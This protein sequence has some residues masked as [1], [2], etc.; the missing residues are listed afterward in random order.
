VF[1]GPKIRARSKFAAEIM[2]KQPILGRIFA[3]RDGTVWQKRREG[4]ERHDRSQKPG[5][6]F[7]FRGSI[8]LPV[9][10]IKPS[11]GV[12]VGDMDVLPQKWSLSKGT[13]NHEIMITTLE[14]EF[15]D[16]T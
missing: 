10:W 4:L 16:R 12:I 11:P 8:W 13:Q 3:T 7:G 15:L 9:D 2:W 1:Y 14:S 5:S 6:R